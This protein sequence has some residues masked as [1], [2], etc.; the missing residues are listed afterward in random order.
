[1]RVMAGVAVLTGV[2]AG[3]K[4]API[5]RTC[6]RK[7]FL[8]ELADE[9][10]KFKHQHEDDERYWRVNFLYENIKIWTHAICSRNRTS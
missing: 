3:N 5:S 7:Q 4:V 2:T 8:E 10:L 6:Y 9:A 1:M